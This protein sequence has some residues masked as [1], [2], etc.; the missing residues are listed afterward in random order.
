LEVRS[1]FIGRFQPF[2]IGHLADIKSIITKGEYCIITIAAANKVGTWRN[3]LTGDEREMILRETLAEEEKLNPGSVPPDRYEI[4]QL[5]DID[6]DARWAQY[7][8][9]SLPKF[10]K[11]YSGS[12]FV[13][14]FFEK[15]PQFETLPITF[16]LDNE[17]ERLCATT[18]RKK[19]LKWEDYGDYIRPKTG[20]ILD[21]LAF[22]ERLV[23]VTPKPVDVTH[24]TT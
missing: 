4:H 1:L 16:V 8:V 24:I 5:A 10:N 20:E 22:R 17:G 13:R 21:K 14:S 7:V 2:H 11:I 3:P 9:D 12:A 15:N 18:I 6:D 23:R 19:V